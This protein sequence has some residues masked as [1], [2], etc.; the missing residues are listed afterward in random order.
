MSWEIMFCLSIYICLSFP[1]LLLLLF[2]YLFIFCII[3]IFKQHAEC[4]SNHC[5]VPQSLHISKLM[6]DLGEDACR[7]INMHFISYA[8]VLPHCHSVFWCQALREDTLLALPSMGLFFLVLA[9]I[10]SAFE[11]A[12]SVCLSVCQWATGAWL[13]VFDILKVLLMM[14]FLFVCLL[15]YFLF[16][17]P[18]MTLVWTFVPFNTLWTG[19]GYVC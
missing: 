1:S 13:S 10:Y 8:H 3:I 7:P 11:L 2:L 19:I 16:S 18:A 4:C 17:L 6:K 15:E 9:N 5:W 12:L 14:T